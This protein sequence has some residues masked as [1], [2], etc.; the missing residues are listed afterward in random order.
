MVKFCPM[1][2]NMFGYKINPA[3]NKLNYVCATCGNT[4][5]VVNHCL[6]INELNTK[7]LDY[8]L[9]PNM[10]YDNTLART[11]KIPCPNPECSYVKSA[12][13]SDKKEDTDSTDDNPE[14]ITFQYNPNALKTAYMCTACETYWKN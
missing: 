4:E 6:T 9:N 14:I 7:T 13:N 2:N 10:I 5:A 3:T 1:C 11:K 8:P 12:K